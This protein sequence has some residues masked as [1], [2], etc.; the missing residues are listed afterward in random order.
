MG[1]RRL[2]KWLA[3]PIPDPG[4]RTAVNAI[5]ADG[6][7]ETVCRNASCP[8]IGECYGEGTATFMILGGVCTR[9]CRF[10]GVSKGRPGPP[11]ADEP[12]AVAEAIGKM[13]LRYA[14]VTSVT[15]DDLEDGGAAHFAS[16]IAAIREMNEDCLVEVLT[17]DFGGDLAAVETAVAARP[18]VYNHNIETVPRLYERVRPGAGFRRSLALLEHVKSV[19]ESMITKSGMMLGLGESTDEVI[20]ALEALRSVGC[21]SVT[22][23]QYLKPSAGCLDVERYVSPPE[24]DKIGRSAKR[25]GFASVASGPFVRSSYHAAEM[26]GGGGS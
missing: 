15:R 9:G 25:M 5:L 14:V 10:C 3:R 21:D 8:N 17:P 4:K 19:D 11:R 2:P 18:D 6:R 20:E 7:L 13:G 1:E 22:L 12:L 24:F 16:T 26:A 23:G